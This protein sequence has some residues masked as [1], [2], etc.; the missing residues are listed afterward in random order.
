MEGRRWMRKGSARECLRCG[1]CM[2]AGHARGMRVHSRRRR[3]QVKLRKGREGSA[4]R[5]RRQT[6]PRPSLGRLG[7]AAWCRSR[8][9]RGSGPHWA[10]WTTALT[11]LGL[12]W[13]I[14][15][16]SGLMLRRGLQCMTSALTRRFKST[17][18]CECHL[19][20]AARQMR[21]PRMPPRRFRC[22]FPWT[23]T[24][25]AALT[26]QPAS[27]PP[28][29]TCRQP[30]PCQPCPPQPRRQ[31][32]Q[33]GRRR[34][35]TARTRPK[36]TQAHTQARYPQPATHR[37]MGA[38]RRKPVRAMDVAQT[39]RARKRTKRMRVAG[40]TGTTRKAGTRRRPAGPMA[41][42]GQIVPVPRRLRERRRPAGAGERSVAVWFPP[43]G[44]GAYAHKR[45]CRKADGAARRNQLA[46]MGRAGMAA[47]P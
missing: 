24:R 41:S 18:C 14:H 19:S 10:E 29:V 6:Q 45:A 33:A 1:E 17:C 30:C 25:K 20:P 12:Q 8:R 39:G 31:A 2:K 28:A 15:S 32:S 3:R 34:Q 5:R 13:R 16:C 42:R 35:S 21:L 9:S 40:M 44:G 37:W 4:G 11:I 47:P 22:A 27:P 43:P 23:S 26:F 38:G 36:A 46:V 7:P